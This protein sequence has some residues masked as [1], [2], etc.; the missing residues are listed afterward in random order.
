MSQR[1]LY[2]QIRYQSANSLHVLT[3]P[4]LSPTRF[5]T[6]PAVALIRSELLFHTDS[7]TSLLRTIYSSNAM[8]RYRYD[9]VEQMQKQFKDHPQVKVTGYGHLGDGHHPLY[10]SLSPLSLPRFPPIDYLHSFFG[11][12][13]SPAEYDILCNSGN[14]H[15]NIIAPKHEQQYLSLIEPFVYEY[16]GTHPFAHT[17]RLRAHLEFF[18]FHHHVAAVIVIL[19]LLL[20]SS[21]HFNTCLYTS[22]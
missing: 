6:L 4:D 18:C 12:V 1:G 5:L 20:I 22:L 11:F 2:L 7:L 10:S 15:L 14:L 16:T 17:L 19:S 21:R 3:Q 9:L 8:G 13:F